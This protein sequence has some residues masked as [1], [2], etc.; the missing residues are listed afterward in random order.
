MNHYS[1]GFQTPGEKV[2]GPQKTY[3]KHRTSGGLG[4][5]ATVTGW[6]VDDPCTNNPITISSRPEN[7]ENLR[8]SQVSCLQTCPCRR[9]AQCRPATLHKNWILLRYFQQFSKHGGC[10]RV[11][12]Y[13]EM[14]Y[15]GVRINSATTPPKTNIEPKKWWFGSMFFLLQGAFFR[16]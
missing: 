8:P 3:L 16:F 5:I 10:N 12:T 1:L 6:E 2:F 4:T 9:V 13:F 15:V 14:E 11:R 7:S